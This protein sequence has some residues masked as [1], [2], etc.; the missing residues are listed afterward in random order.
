MRNKVIKCSNI[1][2]GHVLLRFMTNY[3]NY[4]ENR[5]HSWNYISLRLVIYAC[6]RP[7]LAVQ[8]ENQRKNKMHLKKVEN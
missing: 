3:S 4:N 5:N 6:T 1:L 8:D 7:T 2:A